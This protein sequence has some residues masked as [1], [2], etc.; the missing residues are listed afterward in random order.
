VRTLI[1]TSLLLFGSTLPVDAVAD[2]NDQLV[3]FCHQAIEQLTFDI[4]GS[5]KVDKVPESETLSEVD[6]VI[7]HFNDESQSTKFNAVVIHAI[8]H[9]VYHEHDKLEAAMVDAERECVRFHSSTGA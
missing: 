4:Y 1:L 3:E 8:I 6:R 5:M 9:A 2:Q 7:K